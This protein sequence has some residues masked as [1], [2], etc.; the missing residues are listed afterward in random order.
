MTRVR[1]REARRR[2][3]GAPAGYGFIPGREIIRRDWQ[4]VERAIVA[5][6]RSGY[7][8]APASLARKAADVVAVYGVGP[9]LARRIVRTAAGECCHKRLSTRYPQGYALRADAGGVGS[10]SPVEKG[11]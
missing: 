9:K 5:L 6:V 7:A 8:Q 11:A 1:E 3:A 10:D 2:I 4:R